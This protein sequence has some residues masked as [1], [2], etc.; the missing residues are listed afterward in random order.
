[1]NNNKKW[2]NIGTKKQLTAGINLILLTDNKGD[3][4]KL[5]LGV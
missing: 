4:G 5:S 3:G 1:M 2:R